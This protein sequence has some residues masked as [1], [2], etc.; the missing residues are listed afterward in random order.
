MELDLQSLF[1]FWLLCTAVIN[2][3]WLGPVTPPPPAFG[4]M[5][6]TRALLV[7]Q[8]RRHLF[9]TPC[10]IKLQ[11]CFFI[12]HPSPPPPPPANICL[13]LGTGITHTTHQLSRL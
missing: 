3:H 7:S 12:P 13:Y 4:L 2:N 10:A 5:R 6:Y 9:L 11:H 8:D 1:L